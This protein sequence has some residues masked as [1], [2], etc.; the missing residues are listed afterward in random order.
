MN[1]LQN[2]GSTGLKI[3]GW[4]IAIVCIGLIGMNV[5]QSFLGGRSP[6]SSIAQK[7]FN[8]SGYTH[9]LNHAALGS[10]K[11]NDLVDG[12]IDGSD[13]DVLRWKSATQQDCK[14]WLDF[15]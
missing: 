12:F 3:V 15:Q 9:C 11:M 2:A 1:K 8:A 7:A 13:E 4:T 5:T 6:Q 14:K 10:A